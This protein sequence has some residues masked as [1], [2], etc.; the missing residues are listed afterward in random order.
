MLAAVS[1]GQVPA[2]PTNVRV[3][4]VPVEHQEHAYFEMLSARSSLHRAYPLRSQA[5]IEHPDAIRGGG[6]IQNEPIL[7]DPAMDAA[8]VSFLVESVDARSGPGGPG[9]AS[10]QQWR[11]PIDVVDG[12]AFITWD[13]KLSDGHRWTDDDHAQWRTGDQVGQ[14]P[15]HK[16]FMIGNL[17]GPEW[18]LGGHRWMLFNASYRGFWTRP[19]LDD[20]QVAEMVMSVGE[21]NPIALG[22]GTT[23]PS[24][25]ILPKAGDWYVRWDRWTRV[26]VLIDGLVDDGQPSPVVVSIWYSDE[27]RE[28]HLMYDRVNLILGPQGLDRFWLEWN[29]SADRVPPNRDR[30]AWV[31]NLVILVDEP[32]PVGL[33][34]APG[35]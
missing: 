25:E 26:H 24:E 21:G 18:P 17:T 16:A 15:N 1:L 9:S 8:R 14:I 5:D 20:E 12:D 23:A 27:D 19:D 31:R 29:A 28:P 13:F 4:M 6:R 22:P 32:D 2:A 30:Y 33:V 34:E 3:D 11:Y 10:S 7:Y 35:R